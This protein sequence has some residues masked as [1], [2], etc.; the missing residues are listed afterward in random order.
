VIYLYINGS[1][2]LQAADST[3]TS[4]NPGIGFFLDNNNGTSSPGHS[5]DFGF[6]SFTAS[7]SITGTGGHHHQ[8]Q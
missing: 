5:T 7:D 8:H 1:L 6:S 2:I 4:G 3:Y